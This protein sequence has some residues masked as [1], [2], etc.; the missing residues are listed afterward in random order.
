MYFL[1]IKSNFSVAS[2]SSFCGNCHKSQKSWWG[3][4]GN[5]SVSIN[6]PSEPSLLGFSLFHCCGKAV[7]HRA[8]RTWPALV[9]S[10]GQAG[11]SSQRNFRALRSFPAVETQWC[12]SLCTGKHRFWYFDGFGWLWSVLSSQLRVGWGFSTR[13]AFSRWRNEL[14]TNPRWDKPPQN[15]LAH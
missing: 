13:F 3:V 15:D 1:Y 6:T 11:S 5:P 4:G 9:V 14:R 2:A 8:G 10:G 7:L 12:R